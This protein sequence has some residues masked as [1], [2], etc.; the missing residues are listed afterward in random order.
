MSKYTTEVR[1]ICEHYAG[2][3]E[4]EGYNKIADI[5]ANSRSKVFDFEYPIFDESY[6]SILETKILKHFYLRE[7]CAETVGVWKHFLNMRMNEI[8]PYYN[9]LYNSELIE[10]NPLYDVDLTKDYTKDTKGQGSETEIFDG[11]TKNTDVETE[12][13]ERD[14]TTEGKSET[15]RDFSKSGTDGDVRK[16]TRWDIYS[17]TP[18]GGLTNVENETYLTNARKIIDDGT[19][20]LRTI[21]ET[22]D[23]DSVTEYDETQGGETNRTRN[24]T[25]NKKTDDERTKSRNLQDLED[26]IE[27]IK[28]KTGGTSFSKLL[29]EFRE[30][31]LNIDVMII[32]DLNDLFFGLW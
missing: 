21:S 4:S 30:T 12:N 23:D 32:N 20:S 27:H 5:I 6:R 31:F 1:F 14:L 26:Y 8:M 17:D 2:L 28:G 7:I 13:I 9:K 19:G 18:Q 29:Q 16:N 24:Y 15:N 22:N 10:F 11:T 25:G 3:E